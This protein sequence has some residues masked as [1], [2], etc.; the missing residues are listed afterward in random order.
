MC[1]NC[2]LLAGRARQTNPQTHRQTN[3]L[4]A[5]FIL[6][7]SVSICV[8]PS[9]ITRCAWTWVR[10]TYD[11]YLCMA[12]ADDVR[13]QFYKKIEQPYCYSYSS[14]SGALRAVWPT[15]TWPNSK[16]SQSHGQKRKTLATNLH[17]AVVFSSFLFCLTSSRMPL[18]GS[19]CHEKSAEKQLTRMLN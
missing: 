8:F 5:K 4:Q 2:K 10:C 17:V 14:G 7:I 3:K 19:R 13:R 11:I 12:T 9:L 6:F 18:P 1:A 16:S 15:C